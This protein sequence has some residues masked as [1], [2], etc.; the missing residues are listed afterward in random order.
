M[1][2]HQPTGLNVACAGL[3]LMGILYAPGSVL[4]ADEVQTEEKSIRKT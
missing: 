1:F 4:A 3:A 2:A